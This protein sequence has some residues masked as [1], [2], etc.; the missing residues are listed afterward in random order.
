MQGQ[1]WNEAGPGLIHKPKED[2]TRANGRLIG[3]SN[4]T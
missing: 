1:V 4:R 2:E 3:H